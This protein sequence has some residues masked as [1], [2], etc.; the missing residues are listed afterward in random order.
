MKNESTT[1]TAPNTFT[2]AAKDALLQQA[3]GRGLTGAWVGELLSIGGQRVGVNI[4]S[5]LNPTEI[6]KGT[7]VSFHNIGRVGINEALAVKD[8][9]N[10]VISMVRAVADQKRLM[11][12]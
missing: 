5:T 3:R 7:P 4:D 2:Q 6:N 9:I 1:E 12:Q 8:E 11:R 10:A